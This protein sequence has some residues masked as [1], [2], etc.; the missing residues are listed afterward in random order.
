[1][2]CRVKDTTIPDR[3]QQVDGSKAHASLLQ[4]LAQEIIVNL[5]QFGLRIWVTVELIDIHHFEE[6]VQQEVMD[7]CSPK[8]GGALGPRLVG[9]LLGGA[10]GSSCRV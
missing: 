10:E 5:D 3:W 2:G 1:M 6:A 9:F 8:V 7:F 4:Q